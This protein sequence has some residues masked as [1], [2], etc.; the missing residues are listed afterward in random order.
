MFQVKKPEYVNKTFRMPR[1]L[2]QE[3][4]ALAQQKDVS[5]NQL[6]TQCCRYALDHLDTDG[7]IGRA[8]CRE[9]V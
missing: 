4:E 7:E 6:V 9:R 3:L 1:E 8:S 5:L 2:V